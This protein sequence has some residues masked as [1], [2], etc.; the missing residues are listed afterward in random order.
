[1]SAVLFS[2]CYSKP[3]VED[4]IKDRFIPVLNSSISRGYLGNRMLVNLEKRLL[5]LNLD[6]LL[7]PYVKR[8]GPQPWAGEHAGKW[9]HAAC[10]VWKHTHDERL[11]EKMDYI[12][13]TLISTKLPD[14]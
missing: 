12:V 10:L 1:M 11:K 2:V 5:K 14:G 3:V 4:K 9:L 8:P 7:A 13:K 6:S